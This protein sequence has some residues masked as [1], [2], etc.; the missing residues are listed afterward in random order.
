MNGF[1]YKSDYN[2]FLNRLANGD[3]ILFKKKFLK[4]FDFRSPFIKRKEFNLIRN[5]IFKELVAKYDKKC[6]LKIHP[7][8]S[9]E[10]KFDV[11][12]YIP[13]S[14]NQL[15]KSL[16]GLKPK[17]GKKIASQSFGSNNISN[18]RIACKRC[19]SFKKH[20]ILI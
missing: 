10:E 7:D 5:K 18:L 2:F 13:L 20:K 11:D 16:R 1:Q 17:V 9:K 4:M 3:E 14:T 19:N 15:N 12:H 6:Q 8:C